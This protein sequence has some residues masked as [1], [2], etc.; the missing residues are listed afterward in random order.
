MINSQTC[1]HD[2]LITVGG[3]STRTIPRS[4]WHGPRSQSLMLSIQSCLLLYTDVPL[5]GWDTRVET[6]SYLQGNLSG[7]CAGGPPLS[8][9]TG[10]GDSG[11]PMVV[12]VNGFFYQIG[13]TSQALLANA[14][15]PDIYVQT[16]AFCD[17]LKEEGT[18]C[19]TV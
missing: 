15:Y 3:I 16:L 5:A 4:L 14:N 8:R 7:F 9:G 2:D 17:L 6:R 13:I 1:S 12:E 19:S 11:G 18:I 10:P